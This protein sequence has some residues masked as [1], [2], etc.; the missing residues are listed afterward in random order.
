MQLISGAEVQRTVPMWD[1]IGEGP[2]S[3]F[4]Y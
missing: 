1:W 3:T 4:S 2:A